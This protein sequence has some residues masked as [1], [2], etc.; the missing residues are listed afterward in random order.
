L[1]AGKALGRGFEA[2]KSTRISA[3]AT[4]PG[5]PL[6]FGR[7]ARTVVLTLPEDVLAWLRT[8]HIDPGWAI[9]RLFERQNA[10]SRSRERPTAP[11]AELAPLPGRTALIVVSPDLLRGVD[12]VEIIP[13]ADGRGFLALHT[14]RGMAELELSVIDAIERPNLDARQRTR[15][16]SFRDQL[17]LWRRDRTLRFEERSIVLAHVKRTSRAGTT[18]PK[19]R[20]VQAPTRARKP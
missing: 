19:L 10:T 2:N 18:L 17:R 12:G 5:R 13:F 1:S 4:S 7:P 20:S 15:L 3:V 9:V 16:V 11:I 14:G 6:K 8:E